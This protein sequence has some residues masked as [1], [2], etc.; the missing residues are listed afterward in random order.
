MLHMQAIHLISFVQHT[1][2]LINHT[3]ISFAGNQ[4][5]PLLPRTSL[6]GELFIVKAFISMRGSSSHIDPHPCLARRS[7]LL[8][9]M[10]QIHAFPCSARQTRISYSMRQTCIP[11]SVSHIAPF[12]KQLIQFV[13][14][15]CICM[16][17]DAYPFAMHPFPRGS[18]F[19]SLR[20][21]SHVCL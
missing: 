15:G 12:F 1:F 4:E 21:S 3:I 19:P 10:R 5:I 7:S 14:Y 13:L 11:C 17:S 8:C 20:G 9:M 6:T 2:R 18:R 16:F